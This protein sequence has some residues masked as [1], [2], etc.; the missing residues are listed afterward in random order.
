MLLSETFLNSTSDVSDLSIDGYQLERCDHPSDTKKGGAC[1]Y[2]KENL[3][4]CIRKDICTLS[5]CII[6]EV[7][8]NNKK[9]FLTCLYRSPSQ[10]SDEFVIFKH[11]LEDT[12]S[13]IEL[14]NPFMSLL[15]GDFNGR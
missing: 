14:E 13:N 2:Y 12:I 15:T 10:T 1:V 4:F 5:E 8:V 3:P 6:C 7:K 11:N 9:C